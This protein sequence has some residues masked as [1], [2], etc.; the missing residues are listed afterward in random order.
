M[1]L[2]IVCIGT[3][4]RGENAKGFYLLFVCLIALRLMSCSTLDIYISTQR[5]LD[6]F[7]NF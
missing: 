3:K 2:N 4:L 6:I 5:N 7:C 1:P